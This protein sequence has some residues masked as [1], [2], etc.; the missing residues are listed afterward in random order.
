MDVLEALTRLALQFSG[1]V[2]LAAQQVDGGDPVLLNAQEVFPTASCIKVPLVVEL[3][4]QVLNAEVDMEEWVR[5]RASDQVPGTG[6]LKDLTPGLKLRLM[7]AA[8]LAII[9]SD[10][11]AANLVL[12]RV[13]LNRVNQRMAA[14]GLADI[15]LGTPFVFDHPERNVGSPLSFMHLLLGLVDHQ[16]LNPEFCELLLGM[17]HRQ[18]YVDYIPRYLPYH[19]FGDEFGAP[20]ELQIANKVGML[21]GT[22]NDMAVVTHPAKK[23]AVV[24][25][26]RDCRDRYSGPDHEGPKLIAEASLM[27]FKHFM[28]L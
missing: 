14:L 16:L 15:Y 18:Q 25:F 24:I 4:Y 6:V 28:D 26:S 5:L 20:S 13:G 17:M 27:L 9:V 22:T 10:N 23:Y 1:R 11:T 2:G 3:F 12:N 7:D 8:A 19:A 21:A